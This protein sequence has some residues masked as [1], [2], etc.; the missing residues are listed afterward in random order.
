MREI[1]FNR[2]LLLFLSFGVRLF[3]QKDCE[4]KV[5]PELLMFAEEL[6]KSLS[7]GCASVHG[8][9]LPSCGQRLSLHPTLWIY[10]QVVLRGQEYCRV[11][12]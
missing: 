8:H 4:S 11:Y 5:Q 10:R 2:D 7:S 12:C 3:G 9:M 1:H 6:A